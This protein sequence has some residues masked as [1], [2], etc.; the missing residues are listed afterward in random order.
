MM[1]KLKKWRALAIAVLASFNLW[2][3]AE[4]ASNVRITQIPLSIPESFVAKDASV[5]FKA[6]GPTLLFSDSPEMVYHNG[7]LYRD[8]VQG[9]VR[10][11]YHH[12]NA[13]AGTKKLAI[14]LKNE[15]IRPLH[16]KVLRQ[17]IAGPGYNYMEVGKESQRNYFAST[18]QQQSSGSLSFGHSVELLSGRGVLLD[19]EQLATGT[20]DLE[21]DRPTQISV[22]L[23]EPLSYLE[24]F[25]DAAKL[26]PM[27]E[28]PLRGTFTKSDWEY[29]LKQPI[30]GAKPVKLKLAG[31]E[32]TGY[33]KGVDATT[34]LS[35]ENYGN[36]GVVYRVNF[37]VASERPI[38]FILNPI[39]GYFAGYGV[40]EHEG[41][42]QLIA[43]PEYDLCLGETVEEAVELAKLKAGKYSFVWSPPGASNLPIELIWRSSKSRLNKAYAR[44]DA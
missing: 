20:I 13:V 2:G 1:I 37:T 27:D 38:S 7:I 10:L 6:S 42:R 3:S 29:T 9:R 41:Q 12:V 17:G 36:Y 39:G 30:D 44:S 18:E 31:S 43:L 15:Q 19:T 32:G 4:A 24:L 40:L 34:K 21:L 23:C 26:Q 28:H 25:N 11:F 35:A 33:I 22:M 16:Y 14:L 5:K 8:T